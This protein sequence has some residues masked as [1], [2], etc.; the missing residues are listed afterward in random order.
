MNEGFNLVYYH[1]ES[2]EKYLVKKVSRHDCIILD[3]ETKTK[4]PVSLFYLEKNFK[5][6]R[7]NWKRQ[8]KVRLVFRKRE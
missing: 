7:D 5:A 1:R 2:G 4:L 8:K 3:L 6:D